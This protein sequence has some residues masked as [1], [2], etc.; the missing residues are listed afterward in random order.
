MVH[1]FS[2]GMLTPVLYENVFGSDGF[3]NRTGSPLQPQLIVNRTDSNVQEFNLSLSSELELLNVTKHML[4]SR[5]RGQFSKDFNSGYDNS[6]TL[7]FETE[8]AQVGT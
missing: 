4:Y 1:T 3:I 2:K 6:T 7:L 5:D 8:G